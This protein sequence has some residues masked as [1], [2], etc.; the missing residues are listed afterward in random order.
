MQ[1]NKCIQIFFFARAGGISYGD[2]IAAFQEIRPA[3]NFKWSWSRRQNTMTAKVSG[4]LS[5]SK[6]SLLLRLLYRALTATLKIKFTSG[7]NSTLTELG[8]AQKSQNRDWPGKGCIWT[9]ISKP[10]LAESTNTKVTKMFFQA[11]SLSVPTIIQ[12]ELKYRAGPSS[13][14]LAVK[15]ACIN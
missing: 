5:N 6:K 12:I 8:M 3:N 15:N 4:R 1:Y 14:I 11:T 10:F 13:I 2:Y 7:L 9:L